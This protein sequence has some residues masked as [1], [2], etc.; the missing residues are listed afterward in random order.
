VIQLTLGTGSR[1]SQRGHDDYPN[2]E[3]ARGVK[4]V[5]ELGFYSL[6]RDQVA[7]NVGLSKPRTTAVIRFLK[8]QDDPEC[9]KTVTIGKAVFPRY[10]QKAIQRIKEALPNLSLDEVWRKCGPRKPKG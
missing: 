8:I 6:G 1:P 9:F 7:Q 4:R 5:D 3:A 2:D 10:P